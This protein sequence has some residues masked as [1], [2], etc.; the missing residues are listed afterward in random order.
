M[1]GQEVN[2]M[3]KINLES[4]NKNKCVLLWVCISILQHNIGVPILFYV[5]GSFVIWR[6]IWTWEFVKTLYSL[7]FQSY[8]SAMF[9]ILNYAMW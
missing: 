9:L 5:W 6:G 3:N 4:R 1:L 8:T 7:Y 2:I